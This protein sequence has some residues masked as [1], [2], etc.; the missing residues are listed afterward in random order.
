MGRR[1]LVLLKDAFHVKQAEEFVEET[2]QR[3]PSVF[4]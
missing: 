1:N 3:H 4:Y 2:K